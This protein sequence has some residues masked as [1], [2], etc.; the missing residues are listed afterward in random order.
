MHDAEGRDLQKEQESL[1]MDFSGKNVIVT[2]AGS[3]IGKATAEL[4]AGKN[5]RVA[6]VGR[7][8]EK[9]TEVA[10]AINTSGGK[11]IA[12]RC[13]V[14]SKAE[15]DEQFRKLLDEWGWIHVLVNNAGVGL[16]GGI[17]DIDEP[18]WD[19]VFRTNVNSVFL[20]SRAIVPSMKQAGCGRIINVSSI[21]GRSRSVMGG[22]HYGASKAAIVG[23]T[24][25]LA[26]ELG[27]YGITVNAVCP[28]P[29][30]T[31]LTGGVIEQQEELLSQVPLRRWGT[32][33]DVAG[34]ITF[35][36]SDYASYITGI[37]LDINGGLYMG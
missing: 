10:D 29:V 36:A 37:A 31:P 27:P 7:T 20:C 14:T 26:H 21:A 17:E 25:N 9:I 3:G 24:R 4:F 16:P 28:G 11:A 33:D 23:L 1:N 2:G 35:L 15:T 12:M 19:A 32:P 18:L 30:I 5:A 13:D 34:A 6:V 22:P 8:A